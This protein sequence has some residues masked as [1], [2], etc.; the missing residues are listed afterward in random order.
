MKVRT[1]K[2]LLKRLYASRA[3]R[4]GGEALTEIQRDYAKDF[5]YDSIYNHCQRHQGVNADDIKRK[6][7]QIAAREIEAQH[8]RE[9]ITH[10]SAR[11]E[12]IEVGVEGI[13]AGDVK[14]T[15]AVVAALLRQQS[16]IEEKNKD[17][18]LEVVK[19][20]QQFQSGETS[21]MEEE[22]GWETNPTKWT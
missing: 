15:A 22:D 3:Y 21:F 10:Q 13:R 11:Q 2:I 4:P 12:M 17:R 20:I 18:Q 6:N 9:A 16:D 14:M 1:D 8:I 19:M 5:S 7:V